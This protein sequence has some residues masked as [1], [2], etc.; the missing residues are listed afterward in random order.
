MEVAAGRRRHR[1][2]DLALDRHERAAL[3]VDA[4]HLGEQR[5]RVRVIRRGEQRSVGAIST[6]RPRYI[7]TTRSDRCRT[8]PRSW[9]MKR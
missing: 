8:T 2:R 3:A 9:L 7:T 6:T 4:R 1:R 5:L